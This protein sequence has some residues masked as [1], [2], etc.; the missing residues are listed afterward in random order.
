M[1]NT[2]RSAYNI[3]LIISTLV[4]DGNLPICP[5]INKLSNR[6]G[7]AGNLY[8]LIHSSSGNVACPAAALVTFSAF[9]PLTLFN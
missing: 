9:Y 6:D 2:Y 5:L 7:S 1:K 3:D 8:N 4:S